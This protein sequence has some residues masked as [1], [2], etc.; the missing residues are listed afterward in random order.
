MKRSS[1]RPFI[2]NDP[3]QWRT[4]ILNCGRVEARGVYPGVDLHYYGTGR[5]LEFDFMVRL[6]R[7]PGSIRML[8]N[9]AERL[10]IDDQGDLV[11]STGLVRLASIGPSCIRS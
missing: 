4:G 2:G 11:I 10:H 5:Q 8:F 3:G 6:G 7:N 1:R 9:G